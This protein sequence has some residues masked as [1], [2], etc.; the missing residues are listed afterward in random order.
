MTTVIH[1]TFFRLKK[2]LIQV[3]SL[4]WIILPVLFSCHDSHAQ[5]YQWAKSIKSEGFDQAYDLVSDPQGNVYVTGQI[6]FLAD[7]GSGILI[8]SVGV[9]DIFI[10]KYN[11][12]G[13]LVWA[14]GAGGKGGDKAH[15][16]ALDGL[17]N[18]FIGGEFEDTC[19]FDHIVKMTGVA[20]VNN[21]FVAKYDTSGNVQWVRNVSVDGPLQTRGYSVSCDAQ[22]NVYT[23]GGTK[24][25]TY[26]EGVFLFSTAG[27]YDA[28]LFKFSASGDMIW[29]RR[30]GGLESDKAY[31]VV[32]DNNGF[33]YVTGYFVGQAYFAPGVSLTGR[34]RTDIF[35]AKF[36]TAGTLQWV[37][38]AGD[39]GFDRGWD[40]TQNINGEIVITGEFQANAAFDLNTISSRG[41]H[42]MFLASYN[43]AGDNLWALSGGGPEDD[44]GRGLTHDASGNLFVIGDYGGSATFPPQNIIGNG[45]S[46]VFLSSYDSDGTSLR[47]VN[48][49]GSYENDRGR[50]VAADSSGNVYICGEF[51]DSVSFNNI[52]LHGDLL[53]DIFVSKVVSGTFC[54]TQLVASGQISCHASC[55]G[56]A[57]A[58]AS[59]VS[60]FTYSWSTSPVQQGPTATGLCAGTYT[61]TSTDAIGCTSSVSLTLT[62]P[63]ANNLTSSKTDASCFSICD[64]TALAS[65]TGQGPFTYSWSTSP[66]QNTASISGLCA[67]SYS[68]ISTDVNGCTNSSSV[69]ITEPSQILITTT[70]TDPTCFGSCNGTALVSA[71]GQGPFTY[72]W[73]GAG[74]QSGP[75][76]TSLCDGVYTV[77]CTDV[78]SCTNTASVLINDPP[79]LIISSL[80]N[81]I[82]CNGSCDGSA[83]V[84]ANG[85]GP[86][87]YSWSTNPPQ[88]GAAITSL[89]AGSYTVTCTDVA[90]CTA[91]DTVNI[92]EPVALQITSSIVNASCISCADGSVDIQL[93]G[94]TGA[95]QYSWSDG[96]SSEDLMNVVAGTYILCVSDQ[97]SCMLCDTFV[98]LAPGTGIGLQESKD[99][100]SIFPNPFS[101]FLNI[102][103]EKPRESLSSISLFNSLGELLIEEFME[104]DEHRLNTDHLSAG[105]YFVKI[106]EYISSKHKVIPV[107]L[108]K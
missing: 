24:G 48:S 15:S 76:I 62:D 54:S 2:R 14:K 22:G 99:G 73:P 35:L 82:S 69:N 75:A 105:I 70:K 74:G 85:N 84:S 1:Y 96:S 21:M 23:C 98:V 20:E 5:V 30:M 94:G 6:E 10:A 77:I 60:P 66:V 56:T 42:D 33:L 40:I 55:D 61:V 87:T 68:V 25:D 19:Y 47:W 95:V 80:A 41:N 86:F 104:E 100:I 83:L 11:S 102:K 63:P 43:S 81:D 79:E 67:G 3:L 107:Y 103:I 34:G 78:N 28:T 106:D 16:I 57:T 91:T 8:E 18:L 51:V 7:F 37:E 9:H 52:S 89:C 101:S 49:I 13:K 59:G 32:N 17:G 64:G 4:T 39:T 71:S 93:S 88:A 46:E 44:I 26:Y 65:A 36:D 58:I 97:N 27:D 45:F 72:S 12:S 29:A 92:I 90:S 50:G 38:Q 31:G 53:L 108:I